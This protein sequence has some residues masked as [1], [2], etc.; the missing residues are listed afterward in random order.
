MMPTIG[1]RMSPG[2]GHLEHV[3]ELQVLGCA[4]VGNHQALAGRGHVGGVA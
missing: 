1:R 4:V 3:A 2:C